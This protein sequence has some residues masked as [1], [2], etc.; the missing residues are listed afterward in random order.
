MKVFDHTPSQYVKSEYASIASVI[1]I[2]FILLPI[3]LLV[4]FTRQLLQRDYDMAFLIGSGIAFS[5]I[6]RHIFIKG[7][8]RRSVMMI[9][10]FFT[11]LLT[12]VCS[13]GNGIHDIGLIG[14]PVIIGF[15]SIV[16]DQRQLILA[17]GLSIAGLA[18]LV[19]GDRLNMF[20]PIPVPPGDTGDFI[21]SS[22]LIIL[23]G[24][25]AFSLTNNMKDSLKQANDEVE[26]S[27]KEAEKLIKEIDEKEDII[28]EIHRAVINS[29]NHIRHLI[30]NQANN[31]RELVTIYNS[32]ERKIMVIETAHE[33]LLK[34]QE[35]LRLDL[36]D[37]TR[38][39][40][41]KFEVT[42]EA[43]ILQLNT[44][45]TPC[46]VSLDQAIYYGIFLLELLLEIDEH[47][48]D[49]LTIG[50]SHKDSQIKLKLSGFN[51]SNYTNR[52]LIVDLLTQQLKGKLEKASDELTLEFK[53]KSVE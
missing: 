5:L 43:P 42:I 33:T 23:G 12:A 1:N 24:F 34:E 50:L 45:T 52:G 27:K 9:I 41:P 38:M 44:S 40:L 15:S 22:L 19:L 10:T 35:H 25:V 3:F 48:P 17:S 32:L 13:F 8:L 4:V 47:K 6:T 51:I 14:F 21:I 31:N 7:N 20:E 18:W 2:G 30:E 39:L 37:F 28:G 49:H 11:I 16:L 53:M 26:T 29:L 46:I 36:A